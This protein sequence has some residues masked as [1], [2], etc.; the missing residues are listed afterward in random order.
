MH[1][2]DLQAQLRSL[3]L[4]RIESLGDNCELGLVLRRLGS[5][6]GSLF[7][8]ASIKPQ[9]LLAT[10]KGEFDRFYDFENLAPCRKKMVRDLH[11]GTAWHSEM[12]S[13][14][15]GDGELAFDDDEPTRRLIFAAESRKRLYLLEKLHRKFSHPNPVFVIKHSTIISDDILEGIHYQLYCRVKSG[16]FALLE[17]C[18][19]EGRAGQIEVVQRNLLRGYVSCFAPYDS[20][21]K[22]DDRSWHRLL[23][24]VLAEGAEGDRDHQD[25]AV[26][27]SLFEPLEL[28]FPSAMEPSYERSF[29]GDLRGGSVQ[30]HYGN[31]WCRIIDDDR[32]R[33]HAVAIGATATRLDWSGLRLP[34]GCSV[35][36]QAA[37]AIADSKPVRAT[38]TISTAD[39][40]IRDCIALVCGTRNH[41][42]SV[43]LPN[44]FRS[45]VTASLKV[46]PVA[47]LASG[48]RAVIDLCPIEIARNS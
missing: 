31:K 15:N 19:D 1:S 48:E 5:E 42:L 46:E 9:S 4:S 11:Y 29:V 21:E 17:V 25:S 20:A 30:L 47:P 8:W 12:T 32:Y 38:L 24:R 2:V 28:P 3:D 18:S 40:E 27:A 16:R 33:L 6:D 35:N 43:A 7:R 39:G 37:F 36:V 23:V 10:L 45:P 22:A 44:G 34:G 13:S 14:P 41:T 26:P